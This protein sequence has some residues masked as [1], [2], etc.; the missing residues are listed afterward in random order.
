MK[1]PVLSPHHGTMDRKGQLVNGNPM[2]C[3]VYTGD[4]MRNLTDICGEFF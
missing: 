2:G 4:S 3:A 1:C